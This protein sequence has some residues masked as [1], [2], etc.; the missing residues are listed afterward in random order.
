M[1]EKII[2]ELNHLVGKQCWSL[3][4]SPDTGM[5]KFQLGKETKKIVLSVVEYLRGKDQATIDAYNT[6]HPVPNADKY[7][8]APPLPVEDYSQ[9]IEEF[10]A[11][12]Q[13]H[14]VLETKLKNFQV[15]TIEAP[16][17]KPVAAE[18]KAEEPVAEVAPEIPVVETPVEVIE[19][20]PAVEEAP[21]AEVVTPEAPA[22]EIPVVEKPIE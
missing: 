3:F 14:S 2:K 18:V 7:V 13:T 1:K 20:V 11:L 17:L 15:E 16:A 12:Y 22:E 8:A 10:N 19:E 6:K 5:V 4:G 9:D 21:V